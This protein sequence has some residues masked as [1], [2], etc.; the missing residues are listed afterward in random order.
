MAGGVKFGAA[1]MAAIVPV[2]VVENNVDK[3]Y[4]DILA[5]VLER[6]LQGRAILNVS[7]GSDGLNMQEHLKT[8][9]TITKL[10]EN[11]VVV[12]AAAGNDDVRDYHN[13]SRLSAYVTS[14]SA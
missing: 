11:G 1:P 9:E 2:N 6:K 13:S 14:I 10:L 3:A 8:Y 7:K 4:S 5:D 12:V